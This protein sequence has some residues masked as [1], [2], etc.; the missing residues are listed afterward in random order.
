M[1]GT[2]LTQLHANYRESPMM[3]TNYSAISRAKQE[4]ARERD[5]CCTNM[6]EIH[7]ISTFWANVAG[8][9]KGPPFQNISIRRQRCSAPH[10]SAWRLS[11]AAAAAMSVFWRKHGK[12]KKNQ[13]HTHTHISDENWLSVFTPDLPMN[14]TLQEMAWQEKHAC[15]SNTV[16]QADTFTLLVSH[17][18]WTKMPR[19]SPY[20]CHKNIRSFRVF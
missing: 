4:R 13:A 20:L 8:G 3:C 18:R 11:F 17:H 14:I 15:G 6:K 5:F 7:W 19:L 16:K 10:H 12:K 1:F 2:L 9:S